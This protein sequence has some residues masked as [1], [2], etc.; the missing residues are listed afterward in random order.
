M[1]RTPAKIIAHVNQHVIKHN[2]K[3]GTAHP[4]LTIKH[5]VLGTVYAHAVE[6]HATLVDSAYVGR[7]PLSCGAR[8][9]IEYAREGFKFLDFPIDFPTLKA[10]MM[11]D[12]GPGDGAS[13]FAAV[14]VLEKQAQ[15]GCP[16]AVGAMMERG[17]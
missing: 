4:C 13:V 10:H 2:A 6:G 11:A 16:L 14:S 17:A 3:H 1:A 12:H 7:K 15:E 9:W 8:V 5:P